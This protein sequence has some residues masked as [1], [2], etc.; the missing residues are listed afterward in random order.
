MPS[1]R[2]PR[3]TD[4]G[5]T[6]VVALFDFDLTLTTKD[7]FLDFCIF[8]CGI[9]ACMRTV[10]RVL[11]ASLVRDETLRNA[12][13]KKALLSGLFHDWSLD[14]IRA[15]GRTYAQVQ[16]PRLLRPAAWERL[17]WHQDQG[18]R[19]IVVSASLDVWIGPFCGARDIEWIATGLADKNDSWSGE[20][21]PPNCHGQEKARRIHALLGPQ[22][23]SKRFIHAYGDSRGDREMLALANAAYYR[24]FSQPTPFPETAASSAQKEKPS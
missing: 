23:N 3:P 4:P 5:D 9:Y 14:R 2:A 8:A 17:K 19:V 18:H 1:D 15:S 12:A 13:M 11:R 10:P 22:E 6:Q 24:S 7:T 16:L 21:D 20:F